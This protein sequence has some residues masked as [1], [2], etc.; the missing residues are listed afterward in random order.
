[1]TSVGAQERSRFPATGA[2]KAAA[3]PVERTGAVFQAVQ[4]FFRNRP[5]AFGLGIATLFVVAAIFAPQ[6]SRTPYNY[7]N[8]G[9]ALQFPS[10]QYWIG[11]D[12]V[13]RDFYTRL[14]YA[15]RTSMAVGFAVPT[16][17]LLIG[18]PLGAVAGWV[19]G[20]VDFIVLRLIEFMTAFPSILF[21]VFLVTLFGSGIQ[22]LILY[23]GLTGWVASCRLA[24]AQFLSLR[25]REFVVAARA[26]GT[27]EG[28]IMLRHVLVNAA[29]PLI[30]MFTLGIPGAIFGEAGLSFLGLGV[31]D[32]TPSWGKMVAE[33]GPYASVYWYLALIPIVCIALAMLGF[34]FL[35][36]GL[37]DALDPYDR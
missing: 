11:S 10:G 37:R 14:L 7:S 13:G 32:P 36:D 15:A 31:N 24:R 26:S 35:G 3:Q 18:V 19:G 34:S 22:K 8:L 16:V 4:R 5:A 12:E 23:L 25:E 1:M 6:L 9:D 21:A 27:R 28:T 20:W 2:P 30:V 17:A 33:A 29:G